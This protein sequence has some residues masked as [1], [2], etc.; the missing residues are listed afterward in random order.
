[1]PAGTVVILHQG[2]VVTSLLNWVR[3]LP[4]NVALETPQGNE[5][6]RQRNLGAA[7]G[8]AGDWV[9][10]V[11][12]DSVPRHDTLPLLLSRGVDLISAVVCVRRPPWTLCAVEGPVTPEGIRRVELSCLPRTGIRKITAAGA[13]CLLIRRRVFDLVP[14]PWF[15]CGQIRPDQ[16]HED[17]GFC[18][19]AAAVGIPTYLDCEARVGHDFGGGVV[20]PGLDGR[21][22]IEWEDPL[23][24]NV[25][26]VPFA[27]PLPAQ[28]E[29][30]VAPTTV[31]GR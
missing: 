10:F 31:D 28:S 19:S 15:R 4:A 16:L 5:I 22:W 24:T 8:L 23:R 18:L 11:D 12:S 6:A 14:F 7:K 13:G 25:P 27:P 20:R 3:T 2:K 26:Y 1:M 9:L 29:W 17:T 21:P 30:E